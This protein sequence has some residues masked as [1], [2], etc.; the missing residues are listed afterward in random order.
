MSITSAFSTMFSVFY[1]SHDTELYLPLPVTERE[2]YLAKLLSSIG[3]NLAFLMPTLSLFII[4]YWRI[5][6]NAFLAVPFALLQFIVLALLSIFISNFLVHILGRMLIKVRQKN[7]I[8]TALM[9][10][11]SIGAVGMI[12]FMQNMSMDG[13]DKANAIP[14]LPVTPVIVGFYHIARAPFSSASFLHYG[15]LLAMLVLFGF[16][17]VKKA[18]PQYYQQLAAIDTKKVTVRKKKNNTNASLKSTLIRHHLGTLKDPTLIMTSFMSTFMFLMFFI[19]QL[20]NGNNFFSKVSLEFFGLVLVV[21]LALGYMTAGAFTMVGMSLERDNF[22]FLKTL[23]ID[24]HDF[25]RQKFFVLW[26]VQTLIPVLTFELFSLIAGLHPFL[27]FILVLGIML[28]S[29]PTS[30]SYYKKDY[31]HLT[32][33]WQNVS[34][35]FN[36]GGGQLIMMLLF[37]R[38]NLVLSS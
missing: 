34:Q 1:N 18:I 4:G 5:L 35:L 6:G 23:P 19:P 14:D 28:A 30:L 7:M 25:L 24:F 31:K 20:L 36:R 38:G 26:S 11:S 16:L 10:L 3:L 17:M 21:G 2:I 9:L 29:Y 8:S 32:L 13:L 22:Y 33:T 37:F 15:I 27:I 12:L